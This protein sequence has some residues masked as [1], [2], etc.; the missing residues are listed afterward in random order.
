MTD[1]AT[2]LQTGE[3]ELNDKLNELQRY[4]ERLITDGGF[5]TD[6]AS[7]SF[8]EAFNSFKTNT[9]QGLQALTSM[10]DYLRT[11]AQ[12]LQETD[13]SLTVNYG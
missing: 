12:R 3:S 5:V 13:Q 7:V 6:T 4:I 1:A 11:A 2:Y 10:G 9:S 8:G